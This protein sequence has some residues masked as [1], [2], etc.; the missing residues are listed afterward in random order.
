[1]TPRV[2]SQLCSSKMMICFQARAALLV[3]GMVT[4]A[5]DEDG[6]IVDNEEFFQTLKEGTVFI[7][8]TKG[9]SWYP[10]KVRSHHAQFVVLQSVTFSFFSS[11]TGSSRR[12]GGPNVR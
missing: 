7:A 8:L 3:G 1:M 10:A 12:R 9:Q 4:L 5:L 11:A 2:P 6:T